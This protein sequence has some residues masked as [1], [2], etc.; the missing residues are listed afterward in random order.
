MPLH[1]VY[2]TTAATMPRPSKHSHRMCDGRKS[3]DAVNRA[4]GDRHRNGQRVCL[5]A[6]GFEIMIIT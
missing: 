1:R 3:N 4:V 5:G 2:A 6:Y